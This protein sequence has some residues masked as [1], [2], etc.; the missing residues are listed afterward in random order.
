MREKCNLWI[1]FFYVWPLARL[2]VRKASKEVDKM[3]ICSNTVHLK[4]HFNCP[5]K[6]AVEPMTKDTCTCCITKA[7]LFHVSRC[8]NICMCVSCSVNMLRVLPCVAVCP[9]SVV[10]MVSV[11]LDG[12]VCVTCTKVILK[13]IQLPHPHFSTWW[14]TQRCRRILVALSQSLCFYY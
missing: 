12:K 13:P 14:I 9:S 7:S 5:F 4:W 11:R 10:R 2:L 6:S 1:L 8:L 3:C